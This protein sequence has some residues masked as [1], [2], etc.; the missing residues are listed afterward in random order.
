[1][2][3]RIDIELSGWRSV[4]AK[5]YWDSPGMDTLVLKASTKGCDC[6]SEEVPVTRE[7]LDKII[8][9][10][11]VDITNLMLLRDKLT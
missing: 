6:C 5:T 3:D 7:L 8:T 2:S 9:D 4:R 1:M 11:G 10:L